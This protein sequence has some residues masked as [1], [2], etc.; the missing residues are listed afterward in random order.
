M[1]NRIGR[2]LGSGGTSQVY[3]WDTDQ[4]I[5]IYKAHVDDNVINNERYIGELLNKF[6]LDIPKLLGS[7]FIKEKQALIYERIQG[8]VFA[9]P[10]LH[11]CYEIRMAYQYAKMH[12]EIHKKITT[13]LPSL[14]EMLRQRILSLQDKLEELQEG[15]LDSLLRLLDR[16]PHGQRLCHGD[17]Q[18]FNIIG[19]ETGYRV[20]DWNGACFGNPCLD[21]A[22]SYMTLNSPVVD[23]LLSDAIARVFRKFNE[24]YLLH[25]CDLSG[26]N[27]QKIL[28]CIP[29]VAARRL[30]DN[31]Y[32]DNGTAKIEK[33]WLYGLLETVSF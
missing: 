11:G 19:D 13:E 29:I 3:E 24:D 5:K 15:L 33:D 20:I 18:P 10:L 31:V 7:T 25:Y 6:I 17:F 21:V 26:I 16:I 22:W 28:E 8:N 32:H 30:H 23:H 2:L 14:H 9:D 4:V 12:Y 27:R 1:E